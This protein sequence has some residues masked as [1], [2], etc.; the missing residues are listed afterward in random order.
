MMQNSDINRYYSMTDKAFVKEISNSLKQMRLN[1]NISQEDLAKKS[2]LDR[3]TISR[4][5][6]G[7]AGTI[8]TIVKI[9]R[10]LNRLDLFNVFYEEPVISPIRLLKLEQHKRKKASPKKGS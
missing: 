5:E 8:L 6:G 9:L 1:N 7:D 2:G 3:T 4:L 10:A